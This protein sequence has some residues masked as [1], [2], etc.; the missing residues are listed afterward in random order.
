MKWFFE[1]DKTAGVIT[2][3]GHIR[4]AH[5]PVDK[6]ELPNNAM[7]FCLG[8]WDVVLQELYKTNLI[9]EKL[10]RFCGTSPVYQIEGVN[11]WC[12]LHGGVGAPV[13]ADTIETL[14]AFGVKK[15][16]L[17]GLAGGFGEDVQI[18]DIVLPNKIL[19]E[20]G[21]SRHYGFGDWTDVDFAEKKRLHTCLKKKYKVKETST[22]TTDAV[23]R[24]TFFKEELW[25]KQGCV[26]VDMEASAF[27][28]IC[29][30]FGLE[31][32]VVLRISDKHP[33]TED[34]PKWEFG[35]KLDYRREFLSTIIDFYIGKEK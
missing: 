4:S 24:Q 34:A 3:S 11:D 18:G 6:F 17:V 23:Y 13:I 22:V 27:V 32:S 5:K 28:N 12:F 20:E 14:R 15:L 30:Y 31:Y 1:E 8:K 29:K 7:I 9:L 10:P 35:A 26:A 16:V 25:R 19:S 33:L 2:G 21:T